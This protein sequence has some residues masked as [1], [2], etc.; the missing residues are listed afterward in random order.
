MLPYGF[1]CVCDQSLR[2]ALSGVLVRTAS[3]FVILRIVF[4]F[5]Y[6]FAKK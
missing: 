5:V 2:I 3:L 6:V 1:A 4:V